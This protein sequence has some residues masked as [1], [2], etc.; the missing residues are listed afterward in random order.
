MCIYFGQ[1]LR[2]RISLRDFW[3]LE[4][5][6]IEHAPVNRVATRGVDGYAHSTGKQTIETRR[7]AS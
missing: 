7:V 1:K 4:T 3:V 5:Q 2:D 6:A